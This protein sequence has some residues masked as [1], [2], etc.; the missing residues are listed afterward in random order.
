MMTKEFD[1][2]RLGLED[3]IKELR[4]QNKQFKF[5][6][7]RLELLENDTIKTKTVGIQLKLED[8]TDFNDVDDIRSYF[9]NLNSFIMEGQKQPQDWV[10][11]VISDILNRK[12]IA[13]Y[14]DYKE[15]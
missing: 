14:S 2:E 6:N 1:K 10:N 7:K 13:D 12:L 8:L 3:I 11:L 4:A 5:E 9:E 15:G